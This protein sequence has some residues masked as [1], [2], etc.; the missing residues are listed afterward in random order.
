M[1]GRN[2]IKLLKALDLL[3]KHEGVTISQLGEQLAIDR[4]SVYRLLDVIQDLGFPLYDDKIQ[5]ERG[6][7]W[8]LEESYLKKLPNMNIPDV[9]LTIPEIISLYLLRSEGSLLRGTELEKHT[10][11]AFGKFS[12]FLPEDA[13]SNLDKIKAL[14]VSA[15]KFVKDYSGKES[16]IGQLMDAMLKNETCYVEYHSFHD[17]KIKNFKIDPLHFFENDGGL[18]ILVNTTSFGDI[19]TLAVERIQKITKTGELFDYPKDFDPEAL[20]DSAFD[21]VYEDPIRVKIWFSPDQ[22][23]YIKERKWS[24]NQEISDQ[25]DG[26]IILIMETSGWWDI[27]RWVLSYG[28]GAKA[29]EPE[30]LREEVLDELESAQELYT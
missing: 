24:K 2:L 13:L 4:R 12:M 1:R 6:K 18:Y 11:A 25:E 30:E 22:A 7:R 23:R 3:S 15:S 21:I 16:L 9:Q 20:L 17:D 5:L 28:C 29:L 26:S 8:K 14:F 19:R 10:R 27:K